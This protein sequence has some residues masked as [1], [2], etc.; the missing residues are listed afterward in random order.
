MAARAEA[1]LNEQLLLTARAT[2]DS[3]SRA[4]SLWHATLSMEDATLSMSFDD[5]SAPSPSP[6]QVYFG[7]SVV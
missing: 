4:A 2:L 1:D 3:V 6:L 7:T 5:G